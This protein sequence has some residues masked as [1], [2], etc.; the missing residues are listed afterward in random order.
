MGLYFQAICGYLLDCLNFNL[1][2]FFYSSPT[3][4]G[5]ACAIIASE[6]F[7]RKHGLEHQAVE[8]VGQ[9]MATDLPSTFKEKSCMKVCLYMLKMYYIKYN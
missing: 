2:F 8:I 9:T 1:I 5:S 6:D 4:D 7:V 3:S